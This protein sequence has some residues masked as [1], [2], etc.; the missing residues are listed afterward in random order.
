MRK[1]IL[2]GLIILF[3]A[4][5]SS[6]MAV[7]SDAKKDV[8]GSAASKKE[9]SGKSKSKDLW[10]IFADHTFSGKHLKRGFQ[11]KSYFSDD[12]RLIEVR[13]DGK[14]KEGKWTIDKQGVLCITWTNKKRCGSLQLNEDG[15][16]IYSR[17]GQVRRSFRLLKKGNALYK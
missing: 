9:K 16:Y 8:D 17:K 13:G 1:K 2:L 15:S 12:G 10:I 6:G 4:I 14:R 7:A 5:L 3:T 11:F